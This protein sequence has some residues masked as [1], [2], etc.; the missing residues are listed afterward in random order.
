MISKALGGPAVDAV[1]VI[2]TCSWIRTGLATIQGGAPG[3]KVTL[4]DLAGN[5]I[6]SQSL[7]DGNIAF[8]A[9]D[10]PAFGSKIY[11]IQRKQENT[12]TIDKS[13][14]QQISKSANLPT[15]QSA[16][17]PILQ[18]SNHPILQSNRCETAN[19]IL[20]INNSTG[21]ISSLILKNT[22][23]E[24]VDTSG[25]R[26]LNEYLYIDGRLPDHPLTSKLKN[27]EILEDGPVMKTIREESEAP[28]CNSLVIDIRIIDD[29]NLVEIVNNI[30]KKKIISPEAIHIAFPFKI[31]GGTMRYDLAYGYCRPELDQ[32][33]G[34]NKNFLEMEHWLD[35]SGEK[36]GVT[37]ICPEAPL[38]EAG[39][40]SMDEKVYGWVDSIPST[41]TFF[42]YLM[43]NYW[44]TN[45]AASQEG[46]CSYRYILKPH[47]TFNPVIA[48][49][50][51][52]GLRQPLIT[53]TGGIWLSEKPSLV[54]LENTGLIIT[55]VSPVNNG[56]QLLISLYNAGNHD[57]IPE[58][59]T[60]FKEI[61]ISDPDGVKIEPVDPN[62][63]I[64]PQGIRHF[65]VSK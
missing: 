5:E 40:L 4:T 24:L 63:A 11:K 50:E 12:R 60:P 55:S 23:E 28:G 18:S 31:P 2:N 58:W 57:E 62:S 33:P 42:S 21:A 15:F 41:R 61:F 56:K 53:R 51:A 13:T 9:R 35:I 20:T 10:I 36:S 59:K 54:S 37:V 44:E 14:N 17:Q 43:N 49:K 16:N 34:S 45:F 6:I 65:T 52:I 26:G 8:I 27:V 7:S 1:E 19:F 48:E 29:L 22:G 47:D 30:D 46:I 3:V 39:K 38:F 25:Y 32:L 64:P